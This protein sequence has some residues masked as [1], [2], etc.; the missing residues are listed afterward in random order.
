[1]SSSPRAF[2]KGSVV[3]GVP[4]LRQMMS[5][6]CFLSMKLLLPYRNVRDYSTGFRAYSSAMLGRLISNSGEKIIQESSFACM[7]ELLL[8]LRWLGARV[9]EIPYTLRYDL[10]EGVSKMRVWRTI[11]RYFGVVSRYWALDQLPQAGRAARSTSVRSIGRV[12][13][14]PVTNTLL[15]YH[16]VPLQNSSPCSAAAFPASRVRCVWRRPVTRSR[17]IEGSEQLG[18]LGTFFEHHGR[19][20]EK[21]YHCMLPSDGPL[22]RTLEALGIRDQVYWRPTT[23]AYAH[24]GKFFPLNTALDLLKFAPLRFLDRIRVGITGLVWPSGE[25]QRPRRRHHREMAHQT[26]RQ[27]RLREILAAHA[28]SQI[29][30][31]L[32]RRPRALV[33]DPLQSREGREQR[34]EERLHPRRL[35]AHHGHL[36]RVITLRSA[37]RSGSSTTV[38]GID[39]DAGRVTVTTATGSEKF[40]QIVITLPT[41]Q[42][43]KLIGPAMRAQ[44]PVLDTT[45]DYQGVINCLLFLKKPSHHALLGR[46]AGKRA[47]L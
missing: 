17:C 19:V 26:E 20:F 7:L 13:E 36:C 5:W 41:P 31:P 45:T 3:Q 32:P 18:G 21:F 46:H 33:L 1:M 12:L 47:P 11:K 8:R 43:E 25:R 28:R 27:K 34:R 14:L 15:S 22:L 40:D 39:L 42:V 4:F 16:E 24:A 23:F 2:R 6:G 38:Q 30:R 9:E 35:Q 10:K 37:P 29:W 44:M